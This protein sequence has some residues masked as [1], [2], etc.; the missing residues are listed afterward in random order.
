MPNRL[1]KLGPHHKSFAEIYVE[2]GQ[3]RN[4]SEALRQAMPHTER[5][6]AKSRT[7]AASRYLADPL[8]IAW[9]EQHERKLEARRKQAAQ[10]KG[11]SPEAIIAEQARV[12]FFDVGELV[13]PQTGRAL[14]LHE[15]SENARR[16]V[17]SVKFTARQV[18]GERGV[19][20]VGVLE[21]KI[22][23]KLR[24]L[25]DL[26]A[27]LGMLSQRHDHYHHD[28]DKLADLPVSELVD[29]INQH[30]AAL[31]ASDDTKH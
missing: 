21:Y 18:N 4:A 1:K 20:V 15:L 25:H 24:A 23:D 22:A 8:I 31:T 26:S 27:N 28:A 16:V 30:V 17:S 12:G 10:A 13:D 6:T 5:W 9:V 3:G 19:E 2:M 29:R 14:L 7:E 11:V